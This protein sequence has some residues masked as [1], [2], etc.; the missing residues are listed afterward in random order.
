MH[1]SIRHLTKFRY[2][3]PISESFMELRM[4]PRTESTQ[5]CVWFDL[6]IKP[7]TRLTSYRDHLGNLIHHFDL[8]GHHTQLAIKSEAVVD[9]APQ[10]LPESL[11]TEAWD[12][13]DALVAE[14]DYWEMLMPSHFASPT[15]LLGKLAGELEVRRRDDP[16]VLLREL[17]A[18]LHEAFEYAPQATK[19]DSPIDEALGNRRGVCQ[20]FAHIMIALVRGVRIPCRYVSGYLFHRV[21]DQDRSAEDATHAW[22]EASLPGLGWVG[23]DPTNNLI[24]SQRHI[25]VAIGRDYGD[26]PPTRGVFKGEAKSELSV[27]VSVVPSAAPPSQETL[28]PDAA[29]HASDSHT[30]NLSDYDQVQ[31]QR[32]QQQQQQQQ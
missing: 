8:P 6:S 32:K 27:S 29:W 17:N 24:V 22:V 2:S 7:R 10:T 28:E 11:G 13:L 18:G 26:V 19:V 15:D 25:R 31:Q 14:G 9:I 12:E 30:D 16:L 21:E 23:F 1:Y 4:Q 3:A 20:D 5:H